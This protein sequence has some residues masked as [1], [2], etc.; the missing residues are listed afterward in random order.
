MKVV[1]RKRPDVKMF[2]DT[3]KTISVFDN[4]LE[5]YKE[6]CTGDEL[7]ALSENY[8]GWLDSQ[9]DYNPAMFYVINATLVIMADN[10]NGQY[11]STYTLADFFRD[12]FRYYKENCL[13]L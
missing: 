11:F 13:D 10:F 5:I 6:Y 4:L 1:L 8:K 2:E 12:N 9:N 7:D 3:I